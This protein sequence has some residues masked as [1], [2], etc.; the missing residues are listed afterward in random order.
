M[1]PAPRSL[2][3]SGARDVPV[4]IKFAFPLRGFAGSVGAMAL[5]RILVDGYSLLHNWPALAPGKPR[6]SAAAREELVHVLTQYRDAIGTPITV[7]FD[8]AGA[9]AGTPKAESGPEMEILY[10]KAGR[11]ADD[12][13]ER[14]AHRLSEF[15]EVLVVTDDH[16]ERDTVLS[17]GGMA[18]SCLNFIQTIET[19]SAELKRDLKRHNRKERDR[20]QRSR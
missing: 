18:S 20:F 6:H 12:V 17:L 8:G 7:I 4:E 15:G 10:S 9:P 2:N 19:T 13:I 16:A 5:M 1:S 3:E 14:A 11:T